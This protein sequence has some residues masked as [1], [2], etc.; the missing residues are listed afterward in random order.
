[1]SKGTH[2]RREGAIFLFV[3][4]IHSTVNLYSLNHNKQC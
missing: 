2:A 4:L 1:M 3:R